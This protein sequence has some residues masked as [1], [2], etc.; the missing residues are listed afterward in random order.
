MSD[1]LSLPLTPNKYNPLA[2]IVGEPQIGDKCWIGAYTLID[3]LGGLTIGKGCDISSG[4]QILTHSTARRCV[5]ERV[6]NQIDKKPTRIG[7]YVFI[8]TH[9]TILMGCDIGHHSIIAAGTVIL[10]DTAIPP[11]S[12]VAG[13]PG[14]IIRS[15]EDEIEDWK[16]STPD[17]I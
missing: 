7:D 8:G 3:G 17:R 6:H 14:K 4:V 9:A 12:L 10:E 16:K 2:W 1:P 5:T 13:V 11:Y 15:I